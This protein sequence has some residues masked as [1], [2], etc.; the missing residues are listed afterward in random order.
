[1]K[2]TYCKYIIYILSLSFTLFIII[3]SAHAQEETPLEADY[4]VKKAIGIADEKQKEAQKKAD[5]INKNFLKGKESFRAE[6]YKEAIGYFEDIIAIDPTY[7]P[8]KLYIESAL[9]YIEIAKEQEEI[10]KIKLKMAD[11]ISEYERR[12]ELM[13]NLAMNYFLEKAQQ[14]CQ[15]GDFKGT[16][17][18]YNLC[19]KIN[20]YSKNKIEWFV[21]AT[22]DLLKLHDKL[23]EH[24]RR[25]E[26]L[27]VFEP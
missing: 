19:Y 24:V 1:M 25:I 6:K 9:I 21:N 5:T 27:S 16:E 14:K 18:Y 11:I 15:V 20:P 10:N 17:E 4:S 26:E 8:A 3:K 7:E 2:S 23:D 12:R 13:G 22:H